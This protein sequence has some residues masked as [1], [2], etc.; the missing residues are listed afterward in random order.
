LKHTALRR[1]PVHPIRVIEFIKRD[2][3]QY[4]AR[5]IPGAEYIELPDVSHF[6]PLQRPELFNSHMLAFLDKTLH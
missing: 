3:A 4:L 5:N 2:H 1:C 6:A